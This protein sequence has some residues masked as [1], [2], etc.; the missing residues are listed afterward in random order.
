MKKINYIILICIFVIFLS[1]NV[2]ADL[3][4][5]F[6]LEL[7]YNK[8]E[9][10]ENGLYVTPIFYNEKKDQ[11]ENK[12]LLKLISNQDEELFNLKFDFDL[13]VFDILGITSLDEG[14]FTFYI[15]YS[16]EARNIEVFNPEGEKILDINVKK[17]V[18]NVC[19]DLICEN[20]ESYESCSMDCAKP[21]T[22]E[23]KKSFFYENLH[24]V[25][26][27]FI[28]LTVVAIYL[29]YKKQKG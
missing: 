15:P 12:Y 28:L 9:V 29:F 4:K 14:N 16:K 20:G 24:I 3:Q 27:I 19:G 25:L 7:N 1:F 21:I 26:T 8:G 22:E 6:V 11:P 2:F 18:K 23:Y 10:K 5:V 13:R 17:F